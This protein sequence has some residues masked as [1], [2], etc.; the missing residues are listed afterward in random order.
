VQPRGRDLIVRV[1][2]NLHIQIPTATPG[3]RCVDACINLPTGLYMEN[4]NANTDGAKQGPVQLDLFPESTPLISNSGTKPSD[5]VP[6]AGAGSSES[7]LPE[8]P[9]IT[10]TS[11]PPTTKNPAAAG[12][13]EPVVAASETAPKDE[14]VPT[15]DAGSSELQSSELPMI[16]PAADPSEPEGP[17]L[18]DVADSPGGGVVPDVAADVV[19]PNGDQETKPPSIPTCSLIEI[20]TGR[21]GMNDRVR[22]IY[23]LIGALHG[24]F[25]TDL[26]TDGD[27]L[28]V[29]IKSV[30]K[31][32]PAYMAV[33]K[34]Y[35]KK[36]I[37]LRGGDPKLLRSEHRR[38]W[39]RAR[40]EIRR[41]LNDLV[42]IFGADELLDP[43]TGETTGYRVCRLPEI[44]RRQLEHGAKF[45]VKRA[46]GGRILVDSAGVEICPQP[47]ANPHDTAPDI[48]VQHVVERNSNV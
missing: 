19:I 23:S 37:D 35:K 26:L 24:L 20:I 22:R 34:V 40:Q 18:N 5:E 9:V 32:R 14:G 6:A 31:L 30:K 47:S 43:D 2:A 16:A 27:A 4:E 17:L 8:T 39:D 38:A 28:I 1:L 42:R 33:D 48:Q 25:L 11:E 21:E 46:G 15:A 3:R 10:S 41:G 36:M 45:A 12:I 13:D 44:R 7:R 29:D